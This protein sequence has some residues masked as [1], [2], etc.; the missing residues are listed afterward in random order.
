MVTAVEKLAALKNIQANATK[1]NVIDA[2]TDLLTNSF[3]DIP[4]VALK[5]ILN[6][7]VMRAKTK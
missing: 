3:L 4:I 5:F 2:C 6:F 7:S 1:A